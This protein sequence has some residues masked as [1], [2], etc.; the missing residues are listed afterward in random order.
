MRRFRTWLVMLL[1]PVTASVAA[2]E[3][4]PATGTRQCI[5][6]SRIQSQ[7]A[8]GT[9]G[10]RFRMR[11]GV[12]YVSRVPGCPGVERV[13]RFNALSLEPGT[14]SQLCRGDFV[15]PFDPMTLRTMGLQSFPRCVLGEFTPVP[16]ER[17]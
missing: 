1:F 10:I 12:D 4:E 11:G 9:D 16:P 8:E 2:P 5:D 14:S 17:R 13:G 6:M 15:R 7:T 3:K